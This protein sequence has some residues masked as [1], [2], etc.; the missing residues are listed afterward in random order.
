[1]TEW[2]MDMDRQRSAL[3]LVPQR[4]VAADKGAAIIRRAWLGCG[5][6][7]RDSRTPRCAGTRRTHQRGACLHHTVL[8]ILTTVPTR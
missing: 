4:S 2:R 3:V 6:R 8:F 5:K 1:M 7:E